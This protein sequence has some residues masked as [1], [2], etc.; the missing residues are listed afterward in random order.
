MF[1]RHV[2]FPSL[3]IVCSAIILFLVGQFAE[4]RFQDASVDAKFFP[5]VVAILQ[6]VICIALIVQ[7]RMKSAKEATLSESGQT[8]MISRMAIFG[9]VF[10]IGYAIL[11]SI[12]G[13]LFASLIAFT[14]YLIFFKIKKPLYYGVAWTFV[15][16]VYYL[17][18]E[19]FY[20]S[21]PQGIFY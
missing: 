5:A 14:A 15:F 17:F 11:I 2:F 1:N 13:Y 10:L 9:T 19:V 18:G 7:H 4:P 20:I 3:V 21:L 12:V 16:C 6:I 8:P